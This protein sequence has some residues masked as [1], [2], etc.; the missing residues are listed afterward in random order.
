MDEKHLLNIIANKRNKVGKI[1]IATLEGYSLI[2]L[3]T[4]LYLESQ[5]AYTTFY[6]QD[7]SKLLST[8]NIGYFE[9]ALLDEP[10]LRVHNSCIVNLS[11]VTKYVKADEG[12]VILC[13]GKPIKV[14]RSKR[15]SLLIFFQSVR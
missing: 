13:T 4:I 15:D 3:D 2:E 8:K 14:S 1:S 5:N 6:L 10:F 7:G 9:E 12:Y 11:K